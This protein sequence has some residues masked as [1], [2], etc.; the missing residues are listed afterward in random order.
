MP[1]RST[2]RRQVKRDTLVLQVGGFDVVPAIYQIKK[3]SG[4]ETPTKEST[5][6]VFGRTARDCSIDTTNDKWG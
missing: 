6:K 4:T 3:R 2:G 5:C 1:S